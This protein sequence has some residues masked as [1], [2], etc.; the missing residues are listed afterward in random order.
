MKNTLRHWRDKRH[1][2]QSELAVLIGVQVQTIGNIE[3]G[4]SEPRPKTQRD[5][6]KALNIPIE[7]LFPEEDEQPASLI[8][9]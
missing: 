5:L 9:S 3:N 1:L 2:T 4:K 8:A 7:Q 6:A